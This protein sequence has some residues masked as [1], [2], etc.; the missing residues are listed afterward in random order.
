MCLIELHHPLGGRRSRHKSS[1]RLLKNSYGDDA[2]LTYG[3]AQLL[4]RLLLRVERGSTFSLTIPNAKKGP[5][6]LTGVAPG[7][8][9]PCFTSRLPSR[10]E[11]KSADGAR[12]D[13]PS[14]EAGGSD[15][16]L[17]RLHYFALPCVRGLP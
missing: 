17:R 14:P 10:V 2:L 1:N 5:G 15:N 11:R 12:E 9:M 16:L 4:R 13:V 6:A 8:M 3:V 7:Q